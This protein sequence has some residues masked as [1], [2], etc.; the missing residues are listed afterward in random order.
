MEL[1]LLNKAYG[2]YIL[3]LL[4]IELNI[5]FDFGEYGWNNNNDYQKAT[6][7]HEYIHYLQDISTLYGVLNFNHVMATIQGCINAIA[8]S[9]ED[10]VIV[11]IDLSYIEDYEQNKHLIEI[12]QGDAH[13]LNECRVINIDYKEEDIY[14]E[15][16]GEKVYQV[17]LD[18]DVDGKSE[19][20]IF[21]G[22]S[23][24]ESMAYLIE[25]HG[26][27]SESMRNKAPY[28][29]CEEVAKFAYEQ[30]PSNNKAILVALCDI[31]L[32]S[33]NPGFTFF[34]ILKSMEFLEFLPKNVDHI[35]YFVDNHIQGNIEEIY[36][37]E[38]DMS[39]DRIDFMYPE[40]IEEVK[41][42]RMANKWIKETLVKAKNLRSENRR[43]ITDIMNYTGKEFE[44][45]FLE[46][47]NKFGVPLIKNKYG[48]IL[49]GGTIT[50]PDLNLTFVNIPI[51]LAELFDRKG[52]NKCGLMKLCKEYDESLVDELCINAPWEKSKNKV[53]CPIGL[54]WCYRG[55]TG[56]SLIRRE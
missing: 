6:F 35:Y 5:D 34:S 53:L 30:F 46:F 32:H 20:Y 11:P 23:V 36:N 2:L 28:N 49:N 50:N 24:L 13:D 4:R 39:M 18:L 9:K 16:Y 42:I 12:Y 48:D 40:N 1:K 56:K 33:T 27:P 51:I 3:S 7:V 44:K 8:D 47:L 37:N 10:E 22:R 54:V 29:L 25:S 31:S 15:L 38:L 45:Y 17:I 21:G 41:D 19:K 14:E 55:L 43:F 52:N 26:Y